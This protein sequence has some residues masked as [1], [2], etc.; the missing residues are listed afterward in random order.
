MYPVFPPAIVYFT[1]PL[2]FDYY[3]IF[4]NVCEHPSIPLSD[5]KKGNKKWPIIVLGTRFRDTTDKKDEVCRV[6]D[7]VIHPSVIAEANGDKVG[8]T[9]QEVHNISYVLLVVL[10]VV[11]WYCPII[12][13]YWKSLSLPPVYFFLKNFLFSFV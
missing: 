13:D 2:Y 3:Q 7:V 11:V 5:K 9:K 6:V 1:Y 8:E 12:C 10:I 4:I